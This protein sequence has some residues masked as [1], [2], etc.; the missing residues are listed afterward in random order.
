MAPLNPV[1]YTGIEI[2]GRMEKKKKRDQLSLLN[3]L[4]I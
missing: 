1:P 3:R 4:L 2:R